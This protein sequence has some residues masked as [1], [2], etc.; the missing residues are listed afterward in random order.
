MAL[1]DE[2]LRE[3][4]HAR[5]RLIAAQHEVDG[6]RSDYHHA[7]RRLCAAG[8]SL[9]EIADALGL[10]HQRVH[11]I[12]EE[13]TRPLWPKRRRVRRSGR[14]GLFAR[15]TQ[16]ARSVVVAAQEEAARMRHD[17]LG[18]EH[19]LLGLLAV[20]GLARSVLGALGLELEAAR[21]V[22]VGLLGEGDV[23]TPSQLPFDP[24]AKRL[25]E[26]ALREALSLGDNFI[27]TEH[28]LLALA[29]DE[30]LKRFGLTEEQVRVEV[31]RQL[32]A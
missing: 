17:H 15:F 32:A 23:E 27:G 13:A 12:V 6:A 31:D 8:G 25:L 22:V 1:E 20:E 29:R 18:A 3:A 24:E 10:S 4:K 14:G 16:D 7:I 21:T 5:D 28:L 19:V 11:Q 2:I 9:R 30:G 26:L